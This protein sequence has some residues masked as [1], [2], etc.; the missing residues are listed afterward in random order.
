MMNKRGWLPIA[1]FCLLMS[2]AVTA[3]DVSADAASSQQVLS[4]PELED[5]LEK[6]ITEYVRYIITDIEKREWNNLRT[7]TDKLRFIEYFWQIRDT[8]PETPQNEYRAEYQERWR[9]VQKNFTAGKPG[10]RTDRGRIY[11]MLG[12]PSSIERNP[13]GR[14][15]TE[16]P[17]ETWFYNSLNN[18]RLPAAIDISFVDFLG[19]GDY[20]IVSDLDR[21]AQ[22]NSDFGI[23]MNAL[24]AYAMRRGGEIREET[25]HTNII[26]PM[27]SESKLRDATL[28][29]RQ[30]FDLQ[31]ELREVAKVPGL[32]IRTMKERI[33]TEIARGA[34]DFGLSAAAFAGEAP[35][36][37][38]P[39]TLSV[40]LGAVS[41]TE[42]SAGR[43]Y[44]AALYARI[45]GGEV[46]ETF[47]DTLR[48]EI[49]ASSG[50]DA[51]PPPRNYLYQFWFAAPP[52]E[53]E[54]TATLRDAISQTVGHKAVTV[55]VP[56]LSGGA[57]TLSGIVVADLISD[58][59]ENT[60]MQMSGPKPFQLANRRVIPNTDRTIALDQD[61][62]SLYFHVYNAPPNAG[63]GKSQLR[64]QYFLY[65]NG[66]LFSKTPFSTLDLNHRDRTSV[67]TTFETRAL[68]VGEY[69]IVAVVSD[70]AS[71]VEAKGEVAFTI[72]PPA[73][74]LVN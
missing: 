21:T 10:W 58:A 7:S 63:S 12:A 33:R 13:F 69:R 38:I 60:I 31:E 11:L 18:K 62:F 50:T 45:R 29:S 27:F 70:P 15:R 2:G 35:R 59:P 5:A 30:L 34:L 43:V 37:F 42:N 47:E 28:L 16:R 20:E 49:P 26:L 24:D 19:Y 36:A 56:D 65:R 32:S 54:V 67:E 73:P 46:F 52:G 4:G 22:F 1:V 66:A 23:S 25:D 51:P 53:Y 64:V 48:L 68:G 41:Y 14:N 3:Q 9:Y 71:A 8:K 61:R 72:V 55:S 6:W 57:M 17:S 40:P 39:V 74:D 44:E